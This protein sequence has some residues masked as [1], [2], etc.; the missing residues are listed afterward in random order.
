MEFSRQEYWSGSPFPS[1]G[2][3]PNSGIKPRCPAL[4]ADSSQSEPSGKPVLGN[5]FIHSSAIGHLGCSL[6]LVIVNSTAVNIRV[7]VSFQ[8]RVSS[9]Y[10]PRS[11][12]TG[13]YG[14]SIFSIFLRNP[15]TALHSGCTGLRSHQECRQAPFSPHPL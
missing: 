4:Q 15:Y 6:V 2:D 9:R 12:I 8:I 13:S 14:N 10:M 1:L 5:F 7:H 3:L 11:E